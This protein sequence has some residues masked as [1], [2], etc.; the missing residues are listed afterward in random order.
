[1][2]QP[3]GAGFTL[4]RPN[5]APA[6]G[7]CVPCADKLRRGPMELGPGKMRRNPLLCA[8]LVGGGLHSPQSDALLWRELEDRLANGAFHPQSHQPGLAGE[9]AHLVG[10]CPGQHWMVPCPDDTAGNRSGRSPLLAGKGT[11]NGG[12]Q[13]P[14]LRVPL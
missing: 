14:H 13:Q 11:P 1:M 4:G 7:I 6:P 8:V 10:S 2:P 9:Q 3:L 5:A 12:G